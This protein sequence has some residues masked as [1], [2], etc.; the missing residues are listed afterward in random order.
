MLVLTRTVNESI[1]ISPIG[2]TV[3]ILSVS[4]GQVRI[5]IDAPNSENIAR[6]EVLMNHRRL[7]REVERGGATDAAQ[8][9]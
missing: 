6:G 9:R 8:K 5:G 1:V 2:I 7:R 4:R 3:K